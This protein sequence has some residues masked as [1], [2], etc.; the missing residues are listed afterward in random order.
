MNCFYNSLT[1]I[2][3][4]LSRLLQKRMFIITSRCNGKTIALKKILLENIKMQH[5]T[6]KLSVSWVN[7]KIERGARK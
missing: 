3:A 5:D 2:N 1:D 6:E 7:T 4:L